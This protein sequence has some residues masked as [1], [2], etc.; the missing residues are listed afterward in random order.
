[1]NC[2][3]SK[4]SATSADLPNDSVTAN[5]TFLNTG[6]DNCGP[7]QNKFK[8]EIK[9]VLN[10]IYVVEYVFLCTNAIHLDLFF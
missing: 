1:M 6:I 4:P 5:F 9:G 3:K 10:K 2:I 7:F 8:N